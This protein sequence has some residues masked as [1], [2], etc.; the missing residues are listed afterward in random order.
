MP[1][2][3]ELALSAAMTTPSL[4][5]MQTLLKD[6]RRSLRGGGTGRSIG[7]ATRSRRWR[8]CFAPSCPKRRPLLTLG[9]SGPECGYSAGRP[10]AEVWE[11]LLLGLGLTSAHLG[12]GRT[13]FRYPVGRRV[14]GT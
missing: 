6:L 1:L 14:R 11:I 12:A 4:I 5:L 7:N 3:N 9:R 2:A 10:L 8:T 13:G